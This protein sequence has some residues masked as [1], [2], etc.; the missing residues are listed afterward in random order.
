[1]YKEHN[2]TAASRSDLVLVA[3]G[4]GFLGSHL[5]ERLLADH[6]PVLC[7]DNYATGTPNNVEHLLGKPGFGM[8]KVNVTRIDDEQAGEPAAIFNLACPASPVQYQRRPLATLL[9]SV[10][11]TNRLLQIARRQ[12]ARLL[13]AST[14]EVYGSPT[15]H[16]Q[17]EDYWG[18][19][20]SYGP[21]AC[22][23]EGKRCSETLCYVYEQVYGVDVR[24]TRIFNTYGPRMRVS[25]GRVVSN[26]IVQ[27]LRNEQIRVFGDGRQTR[28]FCYVDDLIEGFIRMMRD[29]VRP[30]RPINLGNPVEVEVI[31]LARRIIELTGSRSRIVSRPLPTDDPPRRRP[32][33]TRAQQ[34]LA[35]QPRVGLDVGLARTIQDFE[36]RL[37]R[38][39][40]LDHLP[41]A[42]SA[43]S[44]AH[45]GEL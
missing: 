10:N 8:L 42:R 17:T 32:D 35:W 15:V 43:A 45:A 18:Y 22:Y 12:R 34:L 28:S 5:C 9:T 7:V 14:S 23:D 1:M 24:V 4:A 21:R 38:G 27:A 39:E 36:Q 13:Q 31:E 33:I 29:D 20:N 11:G 6:R 3:G 16:P 26:F 44:L 41:L 25:D 30:D 40:Q 2:G 37:T 19:V